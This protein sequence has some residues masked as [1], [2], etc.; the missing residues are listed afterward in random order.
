MELG[1]KSAVF[2]HSQ[3]KNHGNPQTSRKHGMVARNVR[4]GTDLFLNCIEVQR[5]VE[6][7]MMYTY[8]RFNKTDER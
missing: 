5:R 6:A 1:V 4:N 7:T 2:G 3:K 8:R